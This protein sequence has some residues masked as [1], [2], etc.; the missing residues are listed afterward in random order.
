MVKEN[1][2]FMKDFKDC[3]WSRFVPYF[4]F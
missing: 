1:N 2:H 4:F 3:Y